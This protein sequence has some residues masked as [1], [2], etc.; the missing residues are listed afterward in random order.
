MANTREKRAKLN[1]IVSFLTQIVSMVCGI[2]LPKVLLGAYGSEAYGATSSITHFLAYITLLEGGISGV[3]RAALYKPLAEKDSAKVSAVVDEIKR[4]FRILG[5]VF[6]VYVLILACS[7]KSISHIE[8]M[9]WS[10]TFLLV[11]VIS[12]STFGQYFIGISNSILLQ[13][14]QQKYVTYV[15]TI[16]A[17]LLN[18][19]LSCV[20]VNMGFSLIAVKFVSSCVYVLRPIAMWLY[21]RKNFTLVKVTQRDKGALSQKWTAM[22]Q[23]IAYFL[24]NNTDVAVL[25]VLANLATV[26]VYSVYN[27][28]VAQIQNLT[29]SFTAGMESLF[30]DMLARDEREKLNTAFNIYETM[31]SMVSVVLFSVTSAMIVPFVKLYTAGISD[32]E[33]IQPAFAL[34]LVI[35]AFTYCLRLPY[36]YVVNAA[37]HFRQTR[38][39]AYGEAAVNIVTSVVLVFRFGLIGVAI[40]TVAANMFRFVYYVWYLSGH[41]IHRPVSLCV[42]REAVNLVDFALVMLL[43]QAV[44][45]VISVGSY[46][47]WA[48]CAA[49]VTVL[50]A[51]LTALSNLLFYR[52]SFRA[53]LRKVGICW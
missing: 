12:I 15:I 50:A 24:H 26:A 34:L 35:A 11:L 33:Y 16:I 39:A 49:I 42:K 45:S 47:T 2:I 18:T 7:F 8:V 32:A 51:A 25:T 44:T 41:I 3:A 1:I 37:G 29:V 6:V 52:D 4:F 14:A 5:M 22:G 10:S 27:M 21:V 23:H 36:N 46:L 13:A 9:D 43:G 20:L 19:V 38:M 17:V 48:V 40:G 31:I 53:V 28:V 30:G